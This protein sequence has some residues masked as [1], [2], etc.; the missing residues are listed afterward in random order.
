MNLFKVI[1]LELWG[2][3]ISNGYGNIWLLNN[4]VVDITFGGKL[5]GSDGY[6]YS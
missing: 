6:T 4:I 1:K 2:A 5:I 3:S